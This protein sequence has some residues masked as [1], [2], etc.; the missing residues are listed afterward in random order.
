MLCEKDLLLI[1]GAQ[2]ELLE[3]LWLKESVSYF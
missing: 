2:A 1:H 3:K